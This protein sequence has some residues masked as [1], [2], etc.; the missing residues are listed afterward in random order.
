MENWKE[1]YISKNRKSANVLLKEAE[2]N[3][4]YKKLYSAAC[5]VYYALA[6]E[7]EAMIFATNYSEFSRKEKE[8]QYNDF[9]KELEK[10]S[11][12]FRENLYFKYRWNFGKEG[13][14]DDDGKFIFFDVEEVKKWIDETKK[15][16]NEI[17]EKI[18]KILQKYESNQ[19]HS[20][21]LVSN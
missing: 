19:K 11:L 16:I 15:L 2:E 12:Q 14:F 6:N 9:Y 4:K 18:E 17:E 3:F 1:K 10:M 13:R 5:D 8:I 20:I 7:V 21:K